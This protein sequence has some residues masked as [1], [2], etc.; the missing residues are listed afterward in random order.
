MRN[1]FIVSYDISDPKRWRQV[2]RVMMGMGDHLQLS[3]FRCELSPADKVR[4]MAKL[5]KVIH[6][7]D[8][9]VL[10]IDMGPAPGRSDSAVVALGKAYLPRERVAVVV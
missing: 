7:D 4:L 10:L 6:H 1:A 8:D 5:A 9:Q 3:V 2:F